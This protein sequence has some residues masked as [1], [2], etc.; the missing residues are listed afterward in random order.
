MEFDAVPQI[1]PG[2]EFHQISGGILKTGL[3]QV[4]PVAV[5]TRRRVYSHRLFIPGREQIDAVSR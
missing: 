5:S 3:G 2:L 1:A 4:H